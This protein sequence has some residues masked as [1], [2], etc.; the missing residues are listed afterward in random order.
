MQA[1][2]AF[3]F[4]DVARE[5]LHFRRIDLRGWR[6]ADGLFEV[7]ARLVDRKPRDFRPPGGDASLVPANEPIHDFVVRV[8]F[9]RELVVRGIRAEPGA[10]P[11]RDCAHGGDS[12]QALVGLRLG[13]GWN[14]EVRKRLPNAETCTHVKEL[15]GPIATVAIQS[16]VEMR[17]RQLDAADATGK[18]LKIDTCYAYAAS[19]E[20]VL[21]RWP[22]FHRP[23]PAR[24]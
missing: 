10:I 3:P 6:R 15:M 18:P 12:L 16:T 9:D 13:A 8:A 11:Y 23:P 1:S 5:E 22:A 21:H 2:E 7:E 4:D 19:R 14:A 24:E 17:M 20:L